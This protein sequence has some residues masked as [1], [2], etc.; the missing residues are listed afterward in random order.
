MWHPVCLSRGMTVGLYQNTA[1][2]AALERWQQASSHNISASQVTGFKRQ[3]VQFSAQPTGE[4]RSGQ[5]QSSEGLASS[6]PSAQAE[7]PDSQTA[8]VTPG[9]ETLIDMTA[10]CGYYSLLAMVMNTTRRGLPDN[11]TPGIAPFPH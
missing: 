10:H 4:L 1:A 8:A 11:A 2:L 6:F 7:R 3:L 5:F 9:L